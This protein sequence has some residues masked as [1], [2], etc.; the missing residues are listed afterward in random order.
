MTIRNKLGIFS[1]RNKAMKKI[2]FYLLVLLGWSWPAGTEE[3]LTGSAPS[4]I[5]S[6]VAVLSGKAAVRES[7]YPSAD[8]L[9]LRSGG[10][11]LGFR[12]DRV[13]ITG[14]GFALIEEFVG[15]GGCRP[16]AVSTEN[17]LRPDAGSTLG[18]NPIQRVDYPELWRGIS[19]I[20]EARS[21]VIA[22]ST[23]VVQPGADPENIRL[24]YNTRITGQAD[25]SLRFNPAGGKGFFT[26]AAPVAWQEIEGKRVP[27][28]AEF[29]LEDAQTV[30]FT[31]GRYDRRYALVIDPPYQWHTFYGSGS[32]DYGQAIALDGT[33][34]VYVAGTSSA[35]WLGDGN[36][37]PK[38]AHSGGKDLAVLKLN[39]NGVY[40]WHT[41]YGS[42]GNDEGQGL[43]VDSSGN[44]FVTGY[45]NASWSGDK[46]KA[47]LHPYSGGSD[48]VVLKLN[49]AGAYQWH[50]F[51]GS[52]GN[53]GGHGLAVDA[54]G[55]IY[56]TGT[57]TASWNGDSG[58][59]SGAPL[60][61]HGGGTAGDILVLKLGSSGAY[62]WHTFYGSENSDEGRALV[63][64]GEANV[65]ISGFSQSSWAG[66]G[67]IAPLHPH[68]GGVDMAVLKLAG[69]GTYLWHT[70]QG[71]GEDD[72][73]QAIA[74]DG[75]GH[76]YI[77]GTSG[78]AWAGDNG[79][80]PLHPHSGGVDLVIVKLTKDGVY[81]W[82]TFYGP[83]GGAGDTG[84]T[85]D[86]AGHV[87][88]TGASDS[89]WL[90]DGGV[91]PLHV[92]S[93]AGD[94][95]VL[96]LDAQGAYQWH[97]FYGCGFADAGA[98]VAADSSG[99]VYLTGFSNDSW[100][101]DEAAIPFHA[102]HSGTAEI[103]MVKLQ[104]AV[105]ITL[106]AAGEGFGRLSSNPSGISYS[107]PTASSAQAWFNAFD[108]V[109]LSGAAT[110]DFRA[111]YGGSCYSAGGTEGGNGTALATCTLDN[112]GSAK[113]ITVTFT[114]NLYLPLIRR[115]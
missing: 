95:V 82:H 34:N 61:P 48:L 38:H 107:Y 29:R 105:S 28:A 68:S 90:G 44:V 97:T 85:L 62:Q 99:A 111:Y 54:G 98:A 14:M 36:T 25:G 83:G 55:N 31:V 23:F 74:V 47:P 39:G 59:A 52:T 88:V 84:I 8:L 110:A 7:G 32:D 49:G 112:P 53:D 18:D 5:I 15:T 51:Y 42:A 72:Y 35:S 89:S 4:G 115:P 33:G 56:V 93:G 76:L 92:H 73:G 10:H 17:S 96:K 46:S 70:F 69:N 103:V 45:S 78:S 41:F 50:T 13:Y 20:Y 100:L 1:I 67:G 26:Q 40:Q 101:G 22:E 113:S 109:V 11:V 104:G 60:H 75:T 66:A 80:P 64:D 27:V 71:S 102:A 63:L 24:R 114:R 91:P 87:Y 43:V 37:A 77:S 79:A 19:A 86:K 108:T 81:Q 9:Q 30:G 65:Y 58:P 12:P 94:I 106:K 21:G 6:P 16:I 57:S 3:A 2:V